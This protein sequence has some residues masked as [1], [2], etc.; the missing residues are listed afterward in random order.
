VCAIHPS[1]VLTCLILLPLS[2]KMHPQKKT[3]VGKQEK[4]RKEGRKKERKNR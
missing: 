3:E 2:R 1:E 4:G